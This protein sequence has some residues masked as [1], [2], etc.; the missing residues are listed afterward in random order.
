MAKK[1][2]K[3]TGGPLRFPTKGSNASA[4]LRKEEEIKTSSPQK[5]AFREK[6]C[7]PVMHI[8][9][10]SKLKASPDRGPGTEGRQLE[11]KKTTERR[12]KRE[13][14]YR[15]KAIAKTDVGDKSEVQKKRRKKN[16]VKNNYGHANREQVEN[17]RRKTKKNREKRG[18]E[19]NK[20]C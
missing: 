15:C 20:T 9:K 12:K 10:N 11:Q 5:N 2:S 8:E 19:T 7:G 17:A 16:T 6:C 14:R 18:K 13:A 1:C 3:S 4:N